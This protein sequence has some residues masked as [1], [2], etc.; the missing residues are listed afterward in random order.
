MRMSQGPVF[1]QA[2][3]ISCTL[4]QLQRISG[5][6]AAGRQHAV[7]PTGDTLVGNKLGQAV[8]AIAGVD[9]PA[10]RTRLVELDASR[11]E[12]VDIADADLFFGPLV[13][14]G[15]A[16]CRDRVWPYV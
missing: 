16:S 12:R 9:L 15:R 14:I 2:D 4:D 5:T 10:R 11:T 8:N 7:V 6:A 1:A 3:G 13:Q